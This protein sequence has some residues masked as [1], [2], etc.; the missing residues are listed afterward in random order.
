LLDAVQAIV[1]IVF[2]FDG[3][4]G[5][6][7]DLLVMLEC[8]PRVVGRLKFRAQATQLGYSDGV[9]PAAR[10]DRQRLGSRIARHVTDDEHPAVEALAQGPVVRGLQWTWTTR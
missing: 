8:R 2:E 3:Q 9:V 5:A 4:A 7:V 6:E 1:R 10:G